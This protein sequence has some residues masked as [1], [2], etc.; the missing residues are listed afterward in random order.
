MA[1]AT[2]TA[3]YAPER[4]LPPRLRAHRRVMSRRRSASAHSELA[5]PP[6]D[7]RRLVPRPRRLRSLRT[8]VRGTSRA[9]STSSTAAR[10]H[11]RRRAPRA[12]RPPAASCSPACRRRLRCPART[13]TSARAARRAPCADPPPRCAPP[14]A[15]ASP[16]LSPLRLPAEA[17]RRAS[18]AARPS[19]RVGRAACGRR[20]A[21]HHHGHLRERGA[22][23]PPGVSS[24][25]GRLRPYTT[26]LAAPRPTPPSSRPSPRPSAAPLPFLHARSRSAAAGRPRAEG[27][28]TA[29]F[30]ALSS[31][32]G[33][34]RP[35]RRAARGSPAA[36]DS[37]AYKPSGAL[38]SAAAAQA[39][40]GGRTAARGAG[41][42]LN[43]AQAPPGRKAR[44]GQGEPRFHRRL[45]HRR[46][47]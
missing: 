11:R 32:A 8:S 42:A 27:A 25:R 38:A 26:P 10:R 15:S 39:A 20:H 28:A 5:R 46:R 35:T 36:T 43:R 31:R 47:P 2:R 6:R 9:L 18:H 44:R 24:S 16:R 21:R 30:A 17:L 29:A 12:A 33:G 7:E 13:S 4:R 40:R 41:A 22:G 45:A 19:L 23:A 37:P 34:A 1:R 14:P 3:L